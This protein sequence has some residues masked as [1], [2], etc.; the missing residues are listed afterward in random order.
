MISRTHWFPAW[1]ATGFFCFAS[2]ITKQALICKKTTPNLDFLRLFFQLSSQQLSNSGSHDLSSMR[3]S[4]KKQAE[5]WKQ[6]AIPATSEVTQ[7]KLVGST[8]SSHS[9]Q[10]ANWH[11]KSEAHTGS[12]GFQQ[13][14][15]IILSFWSYNNY[16]FVWES[17][18]RIQVSIFYLK[19]KLFLQAWFDLWLFHTTT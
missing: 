7:S 16:T 18:C 2:C 6:Q 8:V 1:E 17:H 5:L 9:S 19:Y 3:A 13:C 15:R 11:S 4:Y 14:A 12:V 10:G